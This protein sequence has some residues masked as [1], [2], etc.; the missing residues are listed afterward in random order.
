MMYVQR[1]L[2]GLLCFHILPSMYIVMM[3]IQHVPTSYIQLLLLIEHSE[4]FTY[5]FS[6]CNSQNNVEKCRY[7]PYHVISRMHCI[8]QCNVWTTEDHN[9][10]AR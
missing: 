6:L 1:I 10:S 9:V 7:T 2:F 4:S 3:H 8:R 5:F